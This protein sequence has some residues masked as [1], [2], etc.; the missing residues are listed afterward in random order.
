MKIDLGH[1]AYLEPDDGPR[2]SAFHKRILRTTPVANTRTGNWVDLE[3]GHR[4]MSFGNLAYAHG[5]LL[6][7]RCKENAGRVE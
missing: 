5:V 2:D 3:C 6:C 4:V 1:G 7:E